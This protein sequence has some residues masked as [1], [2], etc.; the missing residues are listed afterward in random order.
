MGVISKRP[1]KKPEGRPDEHAVLL[2]GVPRELLAVFVSG[3][4][5]DVPP[6]G[7][8]PASSYHVDNAISVRSLAFHEYGPWQIR[9]GK[10]IRVNG[11]LISRAP[12][13][14][15]SINDWRRYSKYPQTIVALRGRSPGPLSV[16]TDA[17][18]VIGMLAL[19]K[20]Y[21]LVCK[22]LPDAWLKPSYE[23]GPDTPLGWAV[24]LHAFSGGPDRVKQCIALLPKPQQA[25]FYAAGPYEAYA[26]LCNLLALKLAT[27]YEPIGTAGRHN[28]PYHGIIRT[29]QKL[30]ALDAL[31]EQPLSGL[32]SLSTP[33]ERVLFYG[34]RNVEPDAQDAAMVRKTVVF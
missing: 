10:A 13:D 4:L 32:T 33:A 30:R 3:S 1:T 19:A 8:I 18:N 14:N 31:S 7:P 17:Q 9:C 2:K 34:S 15:D 11:V 21:D 22:A 28:N 16:D 5:G 25:S 20:G 26:R 12:T 27:N 23:S 29:L 24:M 6:T